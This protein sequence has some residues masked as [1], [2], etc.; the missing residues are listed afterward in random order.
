MAKTMFGKLIISLDANAEKLMGI[1]FTDRT[2]LLS[3]PLLHILLN[4]QLRHSTAHTILLVFLQS[5]WFP[6]TTDKVLSRQ[7]AKQVSISTSSS[8][9]TSPSASRLQL[10]LLCIWFWYGLSFLPL[11]IIHQRQRALQHSCHC[12]SLHLCIHQP[13]RHW[14]QE[15]SRRSVAAG[16]S[17][18]EGCWWSPDIP[19]WK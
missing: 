8:S 3:E 13:H 2:V 10:E 16:S 11:I 17:L 19:S 15:R 18:I 6:N 7:A 5:C 9:S 1:V 12:F 14:C 4:H